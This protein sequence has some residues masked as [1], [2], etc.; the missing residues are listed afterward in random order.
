M[1]KKRK[2]IAS[3]RPRARKAAANR[4]E[5]AYEERSGGDTIPRAAG[6]TAHEDAMRH[7]GLVVSEACQD[8]ASQERDKSRGQAADTELKSRDADLN[9]SEM[10]SSVS[11]EKKAQACG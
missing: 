1:A 3:H 6:G 5:T 10:E 8:R 2:E 4:N 9:V 11:S 7:G